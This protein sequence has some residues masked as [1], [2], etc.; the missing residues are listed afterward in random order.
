MKRK[1]VLFFLIWLIVFGLY[2]FSNKQILNQN[3]II[4]WEK[5]FGGSIGDYADS[6]IQ[7][8]DSGYAVAGETYSYGA[9]DY[10]FY[11]IKLDEKGNL[12]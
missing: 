12:R 5:T 7:T 3:K 8:A 2:L 11:V 1:F 4:T 9:G 6:L 10:D